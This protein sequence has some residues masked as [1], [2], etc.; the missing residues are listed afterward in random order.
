MDWSPDNQPTEFIDR[1]V[2]VLEAQAI[3]DTLL[4][5]EDPHI[6]C[7]QVLTAWVPLDQSVEADMEDRSV[8]SISKGKPR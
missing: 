2:A 7:V 4:A 1:A 8:Y 6:V 3:L 5:R